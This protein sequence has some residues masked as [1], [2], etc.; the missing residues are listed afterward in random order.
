MSN[1]DLRDFRI[2]VKILQIQVFPFQLKG[3]Q[4]LTI[5]YWFH[6]SYYWRHKNSKQDAKTCN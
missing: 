1:F 4:I 3:G 6:E 5:W 2:H